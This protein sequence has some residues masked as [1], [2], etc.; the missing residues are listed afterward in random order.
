[1]WNF[2]IDEKKKLPIYAINNNLKYIKTFNVITPTLIEPLLEKS[3][4]IFPK[5]KFLYDKLNN[6]QYWIIKADLCRL[7]IIYFNSGIY[8][9]IDCFIRKKFDIND[10]VCLFTEHILSDTKNLGARECKNP[11]NV[12]RI[13]NYFFA[14]NVKEH[15]F[16]KEV[17]D[18]C[19]KRLETLFII[20]K[21]IN[22]SEQDILWV[23]G[24]DV[25]TSIYHLS[26][27]KYNIH[28]YD[29]KYLTHKCYGSWKKYKI[30]N[31]RF[32][33]RFVIL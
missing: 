19:L 23:C 18:E 12:L 33:K 29:K 6:P 17:I 24:P 27:H 20:E 11:K 7:L 15:P 1:M 25:I 4:E 22:I 16:L 14:F 5:I 30:E 10:Q 8:S 3:I 13:A 21:A 32:F 2:K 26:G 31:T 9:D 28:L